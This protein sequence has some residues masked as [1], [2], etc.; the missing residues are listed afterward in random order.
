M[1]IIVEPGVEKFIRALD[2]Q[3]QGKLIKTISLLETFGHNLTYPHS[4]KIVGKLFELRIRGKVE[5]RVFYAFHRN[6]AY[7]LHAFIKKTEKIP[8]REIHTAL[9]KL[10]L[11]DTI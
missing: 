7:L 11:L 10:K 9:A 6:R 2:K 4:K 3:P 1:E 8:L 5:I